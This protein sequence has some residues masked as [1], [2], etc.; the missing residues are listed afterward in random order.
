MKL[1]LSSMHPSNREA[2]LKLVGNREQLS[3]VIIPTGWDTYPTE[4]MET[5]LHHTLAAF[6]DLGFTTSLFDLKGATAESIRNELRDRTIVWVM[7]GNTFYL[8]YHMRKSGFAHAIKDLM[9][10]GLVYGGESAGAAVAGV[11][12]HG[13]EEMDDPKESP[14]VFWDGLGLVTQGVLPHWE[15]EKYRSQIEAAKTEMEKF[16]PVIT[17]TNQQAIIIEDGESRLVHN[18]SDE[19]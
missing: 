18:P 8:N 12:L 14:E 3:V 16:T 6:K 10:N 2:I 1:F 5:E 7:A 17:I 4:R 11:T 15:W 9:Q 19:V 13:V